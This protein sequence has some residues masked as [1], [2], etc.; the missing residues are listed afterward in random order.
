MYWYP[1]A[2]FTA[3]QACRRRLFL[4]FNNMPFSEK[5]GLGQTSLFLVIFD[6]YTY[7]WKQQLESLDTERNS[8]QGSCRFSFWAL[9]WTR[10]V[11]ETMSENYYFCLVCWGFVFYSS[12]SSS[13]FIFPPNLC[14]QALWRL[15]TNVRNNLTSQQHIYI[16]IYMYIGNR[17]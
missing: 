9:I 5:I 3:E 8:M 6:D 17:Q 4:F 13:Q 11:T 14:P 1:Q 15:I 10:L 12:F 7:F 2:L 16:Y